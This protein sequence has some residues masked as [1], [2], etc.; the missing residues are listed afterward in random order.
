M[1][2]Q[3]HLEVSYIKRIMLQKEYQ[4]LPSS[5]SANAIFPPRIFR[6]YQAMMRKGWTAIE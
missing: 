4:L 5:I 3:V 6:W 1:S 2:K